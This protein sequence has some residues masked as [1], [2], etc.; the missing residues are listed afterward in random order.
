MGITG[1]CWGAFSWF[2]FPSAN[3]AHPGIA[4]GLA[5]GIRAIAFPH[6]QLVIDDGRPLDTPALA[7]P[8]EHG[9]G[10]KN[11]VSVKL[12]ALAADWRRQVKTS[13]GFQY[14]CDL[15]KPLEVCERVEFVAISTEAEVFD[16]MKAG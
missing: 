7:E 11:S 15:G 3:N 14:P 10:G 9:R 13:A 12:D 16:G 5:E 8:C 4:M 1:L 6:A 2:H